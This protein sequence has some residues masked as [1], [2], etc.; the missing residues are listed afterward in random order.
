VSWSRRAPHLAYGDNKGTVRV[1]DINK[2]KVLYESEE[3][4]SRI[5]SLAWNGSLIASGS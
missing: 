3:H 1:L 2:G 5:G 4:Q